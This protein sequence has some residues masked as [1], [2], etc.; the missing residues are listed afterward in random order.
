VVLI[1]C[2]DKQIS[3]LPKVICPEFPE[4]SPMT[5]ENSGNSG[6]IAGL[7]FFASY[8]VTNF[9]SYFTKKLN[10]R[11]RETRKIQMNKITTTI[12]AMPKEWTTRSPNPN[13]N[14]ANIVNNINA[15]KM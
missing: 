10:H 15:V 12:V 2:K 3:E 7:F 9:S 5:G 4:F 1:A 13:L 11:D 8:F 14:K 6:T